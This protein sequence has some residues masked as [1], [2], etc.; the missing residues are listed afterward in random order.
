[1]PKITLPVGLGFYESSSLPLAA[2]ECVGYYP[3]TPQTQGALSSSALFYTPGIDQVA[4]A[5]DGPGRGFDLFDREFYFVSGGGFFKMNS[6]F[7]ITS[8]G[9][10]AGSPARC[11]LTNNGTTIAIQVPG[12]DGYFYDKT[13]GLQVITD[14]TYKSFQEQEG[15]VQAVA[16]K[17]GFF[18]YTTKFEFFLSSLVT[19][20]G[21]RNFDGL[22]FG[23]AEIQPDPNVRPAVIKNELVIAG[24]D[25]HEFFQNTGG[26]GQPFQRIQNAT[27]DK[28]LVGRFSFIEHDNSYVFMGG[29]EGEGVSVWRGGPGA[30][31]KISTSAIDLL[32]SEATLAELEEA[33][34]FSYNEEGAFF[35]GFTFGSKTIV[36]DSTASAIQ[37]R[38]VWH[39][40]ATGDS[41]WRV[42]DVADIFGVNIVTDNVD[43][44]IGLMSRDFVTEYGETVKR[45][46][47]GA[48]FA[49]QGNPVFVNQLEV[50]NETGVGNTAST[51][52]QQKL[53]LSIDGG[54]TFN[55]MGSRALGE[56]NDFEKRQ[57]WHRQGQTRY[58]FIHR[59]TVEE[60]V[61]SNI[62]QMVADVEVGRG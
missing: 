5:G 26:S 47:S 6:S 4:T 39:R 35:V 18:V 34:A 58:Q 1:M 29:G 43:G 12:G 19:E 11:S 32:F 54:R 51:D 22:Q 24:V 28:G 42:N 46:F 37:G 8:L 49:N 23:T 17:D 52:P 56:E 62:L 15:G 7:I 2:Q 3:Q 59:V 31:Q 20:N 44:R 45:Q 50:R 41:R 21:G 40:R 48:F 55:D 57:I 60:P 14:A 53:E 33:F 61:R 13:N 36:Y 25:T 30:A 27:L 10:I 16:T 38:P 9:N